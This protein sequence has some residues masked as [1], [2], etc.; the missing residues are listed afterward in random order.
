MRTRDLLGSG[1]RLTVQIIRREPRLFLVSLGGACL[2][3]ALSIGSAFVIGAIVADVVAPMLD[4]REVDATLL[5]GAAAALVVLSLLKVVGIFSRR[6]GAVYLQQSLQARQRKEIVRRYLSLPPAWHRDNPTGTLLSTASSDVDASSSP[7]G[8]LAY[9]V[10]TVLLLVGALVALFAVD[11]TLGLVGLVIFPTL[12]AVFATYSRRVAP[13]FKHSQGLRAQASALAHESFDGALT[14]KVMGRE[15][16]Q[17]RR[18]A[19]TIAELREGLISIG[20]SRAWHDPV[21]DTL[22]NV[23]TIA[24]LVVGAWRCQQG[25]IDLSDL[26]TAAFLFAL[27]DMP[28]RAIGWLLS[29]MPRAVAGWDRVAKVLAATGEMPY[30]TVGVHGG[31]AEMSFRQVCV[32]SL[33]EVSFR[34]PPGRVV[35]LVGPTGAGKSTLAAVAG[36]LLDPESGSVTLNGVDA[37]ELT[38]EAFAATVALVPQVPFIFA[39]TVRANLTLERPGIDDAA[40]WESLGVAQADGFVRELADGLET[41]LG[42]RGVM[43]SGGQRQRLALARA[44]A[45]RPRLLVLDDA[46]SAVDAV[47]EA[48][49][50]AGL[51]SRS[52]QPAMLVV[53]TRRSTVALADEVVYLDGATVAAVGS[54][55]EL[56]LTEPGYRDLLAANDRRVR[57]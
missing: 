16:H 28:I 15:E 44:L 48:A 9:A 50:I 38:A 23:G 34:V 24:V 8:S 39:D 51:R 42:E 52:G 31:A 7:A 45:G 5:A 55:R 3:V 43:L 56:M 36:R 35:A 46:T 41:K 17:T 20:R 14:V 19:A 29:A 37:R 21:I 10:A 49:I 2:V 47:V 30:G 40:I 33:R 53:A 13:R 32:R 27:L 11:W 22:P 54:H 6:L 12:L 57:A 18:F 4:R 25:V 26:T 1:T